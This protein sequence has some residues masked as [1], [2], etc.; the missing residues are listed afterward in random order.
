M[1]ENLEF[2]RSIY[3]H[4]ERGDFSRAATWA[5]PEIEFVLTGGAP[6]DGNWTGR[7]AMGEGWRE[8]LR[9]W[10]DLRVGA[11][12]YRELDA[13]RVLVLDH[14]R[15]RGKLSGIEVDQAGATVFHIRDGKVARL[16]NYWDRNLA[17]A[18]LGLAE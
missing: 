2:V 8:F 14:P 18:D 12:D 15:A 6:G 7:P 17:F 1:S 11:D 9:Q 10:D 4:W 3:A 16:V 5:D 13:E